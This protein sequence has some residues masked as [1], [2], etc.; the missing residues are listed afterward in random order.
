MKTWTVSI[1]LLLGALSLNLQASVEIQTW[2][3]TKGTKV[4]FVEAPE[5]P[6]LDIEVKF[7]AGSARDAGQPGLASFTASMIGTQ[8]KKLNEQAIADGFNDLGAIIGGDVN[9]DAASFSLRTLTRDSLL[10]PALDLFDQVLNQTVFS[11][12]IFQRDRQRLIQALKQAEEQPAQV[13]Q[14]AFWQGLYGDHPYANPTSGSVES[15]EALTIKDLEQFKSQFYVAQNAQIAM[16]GAISRQQ[17]EQIAEQLTAAMPKGKQPAT[18]PLP[19]A[20]QQASTEIIDFQAAQTQYFAG[21][22]GVERGHPDYYAL[23]LGNHLLGGS[24]FASLLVEEVREKRGLVYSVY[25]YFAPMRVPGP[26][27]VGLSTQNSQAT[28][29]DQVVKQTLKAFMQ[30]FDDQK[31][32][33]IKSNLIG[34]WPLRMDSNSKILGYISMMGFYDLPLDYLEAFPRHIERL[35]KQQVL[36]AWQRHINPDQLHTLMVG[37]PE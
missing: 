9:R 19:K 18:L 16:V 15:V 13:A 29:A 25:S 22:L 7:D 5:L 24:G 12:A 34:G 30:D 8:T 20:L 37:Q 28:E 21:Q 26:W 31:L 33:D 27:I 6:M 14:R 2:Q 17:A 35:T 3:T 32:E 23:F 11:E 10:N 1:A 4:L 36:D